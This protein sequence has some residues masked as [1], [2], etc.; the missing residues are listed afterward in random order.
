MPG[1]GYIYLLGCFGLLLGLTKLVEKG[2]L[3]FIWAGVWYALLSTL[4]IVAPMFVAQLI[5]GVEA[6][7]LLLSM[8]GQL[9]HLVISFV[10]A[11]VIFRLLDWWSDTIANWLITFTIG[12]FIL[13]FLL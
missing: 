8:A 9:W 11:S 13:A 6:S 5:V 3:H 7:N 10:A 4:L 12:Y 1:G 2:K